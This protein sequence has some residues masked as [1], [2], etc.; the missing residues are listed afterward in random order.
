MKQAGIALSVMCLLVVFAAFPATAQEFAVGSRIDNFTLTATDGK[1]YSL[2]GLKGKNG[3]I[4]MFLSAQCPIVKLYV[5]RI[6][7]VAADYESKGIAFIGINANATE[8]LEWVTSDK[9]E[10]YPSFPVLIDKG[11]TIA[12]KLGATVTP[13]AYFFD[14]NNTLVYHGAI[15]NDKSGENVQTKHLRKALD[16]ALAGEKVEQTRIRAFGCEIKRAKGQ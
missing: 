1:S 8:S 5:D 15:D 16:S 14:N 6:N 2:D 9:A 10:R 7:E 13:E 4:I 11:N 3:T 12:D